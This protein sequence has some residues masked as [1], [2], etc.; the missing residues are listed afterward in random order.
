MVPDVQE[1]EPTSDQLHSIFEYL[2]ADK[3]GSV[4]EGATTPTEALRKLRENASLFQKPVI[5]DW[6]KGKVGKNEVV[7]SCLW[8]LSLIIL[9]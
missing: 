4:V 9:Q 6:G 1:G 3:I 5:V 7:Y 2:G 8:E